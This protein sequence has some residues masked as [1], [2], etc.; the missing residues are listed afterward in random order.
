MS[1]EAGLGVFSDFES[2]TQYP[3]FESL[4]NEVMAKEGRGMRGKKDKRMDD[5]E[6]KQRQNARKFKVL[7]FL[8]C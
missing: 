1:T 2:F 4:L 5:E 8:E 7:E 6:R 3:A